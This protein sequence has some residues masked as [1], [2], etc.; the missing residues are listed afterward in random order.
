MGRKESSTGSQRV[1]G[2]DLVTKQQEKLHMESL[3]YRELWGVKD[4]DACQ[5]PIK[6]PAAPDSRERSRP[7]CQEKPSWKTLQGHSSGEE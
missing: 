2:H 5:D 6:H 3:S 4:G 1:V 7:R